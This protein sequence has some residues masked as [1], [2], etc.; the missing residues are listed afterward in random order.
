MNIYSKLD[1]IKTLHHRQKKKLLKF[2]KTNRPELTDKERETH[3][4]I[5]LFKIYYYFK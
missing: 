5:H 3:V 1:E 2:Y 4:N